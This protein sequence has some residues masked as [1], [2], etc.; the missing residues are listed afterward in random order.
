MCSMGMRMG[1][2]FPTILALSVGMSVVA[3][4]M[5]VSLL[6]IFCMAAKVVVVV[7]IVRRWSILWFGQT[8]LFPEFCCLPYLVIELVAPPRS[9]R[10]KPLDGKL[11]HMARQRDLGVPHTY[12]PW[13]T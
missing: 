7:M 3:V 2:S 1:F 12:W 4:S 9:V 10:R 6:L 8:A 13:I 11:V 5:V